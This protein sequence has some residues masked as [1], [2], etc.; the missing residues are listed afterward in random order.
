MPLLRFGTG[1]IFNGGD[2][3]VK[4]RM[5]AQFSVKIRVFSGIESAGIV[6]GDWWSRDQRCG[7]WWKREQVFDQRAVR[8]LCAAQCEGQG[9]CSVLWAVLEIRSSWAVKSMRARR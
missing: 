6:Q 3:G 8:D 2:A 5:G 1:H 9:G 7:C 4:V